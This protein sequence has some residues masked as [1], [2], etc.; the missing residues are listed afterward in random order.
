VTY[1]ATDICRVR[2]WRAELFCCT[3]TAS[4][5]WWREG[6]GGKDGEVSAWAALYRGW[7]FEAL[8]GQ[9]QD[10]ILKKDQFA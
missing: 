2:F 8:E 10:G 9:T 1:I 3:H 5:Q 7:Y 4:G 6:E